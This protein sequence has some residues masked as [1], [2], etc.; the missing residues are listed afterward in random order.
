M[1]GGAGGSDPHSTLRSESGSAEHTLLWPQMGLTRRKSW[2]QWDRPAGRSRRSGLPVLLM[3]GHTGR[4]RRL[5]PQRACPEEGQQFMITFLPERTGRD[6]IQAGHFST[7]GELHG[8]CRNIL[9]ASKSSPPPPSQI[10]TANYARL[11]KG[12]SEKRC[13]YRCLFSS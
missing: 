7:S 10:Y 3:P 2:R 4:C 12:N 9:C 11:G 5:C 13:F 1:E 8:N 6:E